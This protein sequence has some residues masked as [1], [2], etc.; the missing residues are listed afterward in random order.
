MGALCREIAG[1]LGL[2]ERSAAALE[3]A[4]RLHHSGFPLLDE[5]A[6]G[7]LL[8]D[9]YPPDAARFKIPHV[10][11]WERCPE[12]LAEVLRGVHAIPTGASDSKTRRLSE[13]LWLSHL[14]DEQME[15][16]APGAI[17]VREIWEDLESLRGMLS[18]AVLEAARRALDGPYRLTEGYPWKFPVQAAAGRDVLCALALGQDCDVMGLSCLAG[19]DPVMAG[20]LI[21]TANSALYSRQGLVKSI[22]QAISYIGT[23]A[24]RRVLMALAL[25]R[26]TGSAALAS[27]WRHSVR[28]AQYC[29]A[30]ACDT[31]LL[32]PDEA[33]L[34]G[35]VHDI[36]RIA[37]ATLPR[38]AGAA[39]TRL[40]ERGCPPCYAETL[41][42]GQNHAQI[43]AAILRSWRF[44]ESMIE[45][46]R[47]HHQP[48]GSG[49]TAACMLY[50][51]EFWE[52]SDEDLPSMHQWSA[53][54]QQTGCSLETLARIQ[55][56]DRSLE[57]MLS[58]A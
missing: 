22:P 57:R 16:P 7:R 54:L 26:L 43:G 2:A 9:L 44:P 6:L 55:H 5:A 39:L 53:A 45:A 56:L 38:D 42:L 1:Q 52:E 50:L 17:S 24:A 41:V 51:A 23:Q 19:R 29:E 3:Q 20:K 32:A 46:V 15:W 12:D 14:L 13:I 28:M 36:G 47:L 27:L 35:L 4:A 11:F 40:G 34:A 49:S 48:A 8:R 37:M 58:V 21:E 25:E 33:L 31:E 30:F 18:P 10:H